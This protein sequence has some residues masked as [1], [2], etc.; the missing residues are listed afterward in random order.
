MTTANLAVLVL[1]KDMIIDKI[2]CKM[3]QK[4]RLSLSKLLLLQIC[5]L[6]SSHRVLCGTSAGLEVDWLFQGSCARESTRKS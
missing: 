2:S 6:Q 5:L 4:I 1:L 3:C